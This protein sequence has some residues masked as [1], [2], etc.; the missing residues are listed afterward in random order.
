MFKEAYVRKIIEQA[1]AHA[2]RILELGCGRAE[3]A[4]PLLRERSDI[5]YR[6]VEPYLPSLRKARESI[7]A[8][9][10]VQLDHAFGYDVGA[11]GSYDVCFSLSTLEHV[12]QLEVFLKESIAAVRHGGSIVHHYDLGHALYPSGIKERVQVWVGNTL[13]H[14]LPEHRFVRYL[15]PQTVVDI[16]QSHGAVVDRVTYHQMP[17]HKKLLK[18]L[19]LRD[20]S[21]RAL[22]QR[23]IDWEFD[24]SPHLDHVPSMTR[25]RLFPSIIVW[26][27]RT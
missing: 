22:A 26:A 10:N 14:V 15:A 9:P 19:D 20:V 5:R 23:L 4:A 18:N 7:G 6:G 11:D 3:A 16:M 2:P 12:K 8:L 21:T 17:N 24:I 27:H 25:E 1:P 13:P